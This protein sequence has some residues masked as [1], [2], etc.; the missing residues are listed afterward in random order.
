MQE[1]AARLVGA[2]YEQ[3]DVAKHCYTSVRTIQRWQKLDGFM[4]AAAEAREAIADPDA[5]AVLRTLMLN[6]ANET[7]RL[8]AART[9]LLAP[10]KDVDPDENAMPRITVFGGDL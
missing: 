8:Q 2:G 3:A 4:E 9:L 6:S 5:A 7:V 10:P 1:K